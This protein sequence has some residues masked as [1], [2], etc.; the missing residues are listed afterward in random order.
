MNH[1]T[2]EIAART[3]TESFTVARSSSAGST[4]TSATFTADFPQ[5]RNR[6]SGKP[7]RRPAR[8][9]IAPDPSSFVPAD[10]EAERQRLMRSMPPRS[11]TE[12]IARKTPARDPWLDDKYDWRP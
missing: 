7:L 9:P 5:E 4:R 1:A 12:E 8:R 10:E 3:I 11:R 6:L 2:I